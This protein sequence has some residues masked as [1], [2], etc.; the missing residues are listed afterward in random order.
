MCASQT[1]PPRPMQYTITGELVPVPDIDHDSPTEAWVR[2][3]N[4]GMEGIA[5]NCNPYAPGD[6]E[7]RDWQEGWEAAERN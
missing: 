7:H 4:D 5:D 3:W 2:G 1:P 6:Q